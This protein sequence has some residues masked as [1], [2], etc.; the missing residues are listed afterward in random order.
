MNQRHPTASPAGI[1]GL[2]CF[3]LIVGGCGPAKH[4]PIEKTAYLLAVPLPQ[5]TPAARPTHCIAIRTCD[6]AAAFASGSFVYRSGTI[7]YER[8]FYNR[9]LIPPADQITQTL[10]DWMRAIQ[11][12]VCVPGTSPKDLYTIV[13]TLEAFYGDFRDRN[14]PAAVVKMQIS[15]TFTDSTS[16]S[17]RTLLTRSYG[18]TVPV[19]IS[20]R[21]ADLVGAFSEGIGQILS[22]FQQDAEASF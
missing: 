6:A 19:P 9:F 8:D 11:W 18:A 5:S 17:V 13:P 3:C 15:L 22:Q 20:P 21:A 1:A 10:S 14:K 7:E 16:K 2:L 12:D 4:P